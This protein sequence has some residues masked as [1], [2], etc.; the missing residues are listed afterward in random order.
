M[1]DIPQYDFTTAPTDEQLST[2]GALGQDLYNAEVEV[3]RQEMALREAKKFRDDIAQ[4]LIP[5]ALDEAGLTGIETP[6]FKVDVKPVLRV[7]PLKAN[8]PLVLQRLEELGAGA[9]IQTTVSIGFKPNQ[10]EAVDKFV[11]EVS[12]DHSNV[13]EDR[14]VHSSRLRKFVADRLKAHKEVDHD[15]FGVTEFREAKFASGGP[16]LEVFEG[17]GADL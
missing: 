5:Q 2:V 17:E 14:S 10:Q 13:K 11:A 8:R 15:L 1:T 3:L 12:A 4:N 16:T 6:T 7:T 9:L